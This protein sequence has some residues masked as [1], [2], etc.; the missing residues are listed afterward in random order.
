M[1]YEV[2]VDIEAEPRRVWSVMTDVE[3][4][5]E[6]T[7]SITRA[8]LLTPAPLA[9][10]SRIRVKQ[11]K[12]K[13]V[14]WTVS[15]LEPLA[16]FTWRAV[17][18][19]LDSVAAHRIEPRAGGGSTV[20]LTLEQRGP[21]APLLRLLTAKMTRRYMDFERLGLKARSE[22]VDGDGHQPR[23]EAAAGQ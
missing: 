17:V 5:S 10:G 22:R 16:G 19:G 8:E 6:W 2:T 23:I 1:R 3:R 4:W 14:V 15:E 12:L 7:R 18:P 20:T 9:V 21:L 13:A 11:P